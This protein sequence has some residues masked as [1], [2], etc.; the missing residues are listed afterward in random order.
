[1]SHEPYSVRAA[2]KLGSP[3]EIRLIF[4]PRA[5]N[6]AGYAKP[7]TQ[8]VSGCEESGK[9][10]RDLLARWKEL[11]DKDVK[12]VNEKLTKAGLPALGQ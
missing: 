5:R 10:L 1:M 9:S 2:G 8:A 12:A 7:T 3:A 4:C 11:S 6:T